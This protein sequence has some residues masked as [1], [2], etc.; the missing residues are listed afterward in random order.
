MK[1]VLMGLLMAIGSTQVLAA[2]AKRTTFGALQ[3]GRKVE[4]VELSN[5]KGMSVRIVALGAALQALSVPDKQG[6]SADIVLGY[7]TPEEYVDK[8][9]YF[10][11]TV[12]RYANRIAKGQ[13][14]LDGKTYNL[15]VNDGPNH[16]HGGKV[17][18]DRARRAGQGRAFVC[19]S[20]RRRRLP[21]QARSVSDVF[22]RR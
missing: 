19:E 17:G 12:G 18:F 15:A 21:G 3:D 13:F 8:P 1:V 5:A 4:A 7:K 6:K 16:L 20:R 22:A 10:G 9:Q 14:A 11:V 2:E